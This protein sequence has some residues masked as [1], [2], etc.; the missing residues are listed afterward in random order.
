M[1][2]LKITVNGVTYDVVVE[3]VGSTNSAPVSA[4]IVA[5]TPAPAPVAVPAATPVA[6]PVAQP[7]TTPAPSG[8]QGAIKVESPLPG[9]IIDVPVSVGQSVKKGQVIVI[10]EAL[11]MENEI[12][13]SQDATVASINCTKG[14]TVESGKVLLT[15]N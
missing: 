3:E 4:P 12:C 5:N 2:N 6:T 7:A 13:A 11:K 14:E 1:K 9:T 8:S 15:L 10:I